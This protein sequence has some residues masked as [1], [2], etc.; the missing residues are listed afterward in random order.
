V[1]WHDSQFVVAVKDNPS[2]FVPQDKE[3]S[4]KVDYLGSSGHMEIL[5]TLPLKA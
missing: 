5:D 3:G 2:F 4:R 1:R